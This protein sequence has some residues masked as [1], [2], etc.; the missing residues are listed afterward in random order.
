METIEIF[1]DLIIDTKNNIKNLLE[2]KH[3]ILISLIILFISIFCQTLGSVISKVDSVENVNILLTFGLLVKVIIHI[4]LWI[5]L[6]SIFHFMSAL[7]KHEGNI[8]HFFIIL[9]ISFLPFIFLPAGAI[10]SQVLTPNSNALYYIFYLILFFWSFRLQLQSLELTY[11]FSLK[12]AFFL[13]ITPFL[14]IF[15]ISVVIIIS[16]IISFF[17]ILT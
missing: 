13:Y 5:I 9:G 12:E 10:I 11:N 16:L 15:I 8:I 17:Y 6:T 7:K 3:P 14:F 2:V 4:L 1:Y